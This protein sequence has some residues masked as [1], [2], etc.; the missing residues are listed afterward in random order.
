MSVEIFHLLGGWI[1]ISIPKWYD[2]EKSYEK[3]LRRKK[4]IS[5]PKWYDYEYAFQRGMW[6]V[7]IFQFQNGTI[8]RMRGVLA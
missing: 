4:R 7:N 2:Y 3:E 6:T 1:C 5:I 8:M